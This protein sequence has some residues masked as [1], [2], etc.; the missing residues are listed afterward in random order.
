MPDISTRINA[1]I[2]YL[3]LWPLL[4]LAKKDTP[5]A[6]PYVRWHAKR[7]SLII[8]GGLLAFIAYRYIKG[9]IQLN[10]FGISFDVIL[11]MLI[12][13]IVLIALLAWAYRAFNGSS[14]SESSWKSF[15]M[16]ENNTTL[17]EYSEENKIRIISS[18]IPFV[19]IFISSKYPIEETI[20]GRKIGTLFIC[21]LLINIIFF[22]GSTTTLSLI[23]ILAYIGLIV[24]TAVY[25]F[26]FSKF[27]SFKFYTIIPTYLELDAHVKVSIVTVANF[28]RIAF[29]GEKKFSYQ[30]IFDTHINKNTLKETASIEYFTPNWIFA[31]PFVN[32]ITLPSLWQQ[33]YQEYKPLIFQAVT[34]S[35]LTGISIYFYWINSQI[36]LFL[37]FPIISLALESKDNILTRAPFTSIVI[38]FYSLFGKSKDTLIAIKE[39]WEEKVHYTY[40]VEEK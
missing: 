29:G 16:P 17:W 9:L 22:S 1:L 39:K 36:G 6:M 13:S 35:L 24:T 28:I 25:L 31:I 15:H 32:L 7:A 20:I 3:F 4:L 18:F 40:E 21:I 33:K 30:E 12:V 2:A 10:I 5:L 19:G 38:D 11:L 14:A 27:L 8:F 37:L 23:I 26:G 34:L